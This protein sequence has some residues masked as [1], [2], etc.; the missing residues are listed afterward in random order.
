M[1]LKRSYIAD[2]PLYAYF[3]CT[4]IL[5]WGAILLVLGPEAIPATVEQ[6]EVTGMLIL[7]G[8]ALSAVLLISI[9]EDGRGWRQLGNRLIRFRL[10]PGWYAFTLLIAPLSTLLGIL[11]LS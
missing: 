6:Q 9:C 10:H 1:D 3:L 7:T 11:L 8:P 4:F 5:S 2:H